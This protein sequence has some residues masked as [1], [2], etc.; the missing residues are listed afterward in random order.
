LD[1]A[2]RLY[3][4]EVYLERVLALP[5]PLKSTI[6]GQVLKRITE[7]TSNSAIT[8][9]IGVVALLWTASGLFSTI[10]DA[11]NKIYKIKLEVFY[12]WGKFKDISMVLGVFLFFILSVASSYLFSIVTA[13]GI[14]FIDNYINMGFAD[15]LLAILLG[16][17]FSFLMFFIIYRI[18]PHGQVS[19]R[20]ALV[21]AISSAVMFEIL[22]HLFTLY[23]VSLSNFAAVYGAYAALV[24]VVFWIYY[25]SFIF[26]LGAEIGQL[27][28]EKRIL[29]DKGKA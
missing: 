1:S 25:S 2:Q 4:V 9:I 28:N 13:K 17:L 22:K 19:K 29:I 10:R 8:S 16:L 5:E 27:Y 15:E 24:S 12:L 7:L 26:V 23:L 14:D 11:L 3:D 6:T 20:V 18:V 21:S